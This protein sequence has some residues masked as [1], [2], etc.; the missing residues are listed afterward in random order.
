M[1]NKIEAKFPG[2]NFPAYG[3][4]KIY[5]MDYS[6][7]TNNVRG[8]EWSNSTPTDIAAFIINNTPLL[9]ITFCAFKENTIKLAGETKEISHCE[10]VL[11]PTDNTDKTWI[12]F[13]E[14]KY[15]KKEEN[16]GTNMKNAREQL[17]LTLDLFKEQGIIKEKRLVYLIFSAPKYTNKTPFESW[18][19]QPNELKEIRKT[20]SAIIRGVN[21]I[22]II[23]N[24]SLKV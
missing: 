9:D 16:L 10:G 12:I 23:S 5:I 3:T 6:N 22:D 18:S 7:Q 8:I 24:E 19:M 1:K 14:L 4:D 2:Q 13:L 11:F 20:K 15:P 17:F 21:S